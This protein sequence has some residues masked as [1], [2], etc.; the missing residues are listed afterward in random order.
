MIVEASQALPH[1]QELAS[2]AA[3][4]VS[5][6]KPLVPAVLA[7][8]EESLN[9]S[10]MTILYLALALRGDESFQENALEILAKAPA[11]N[12]YFRQ[13]GQL[14]ERLLTDPNRHDP[15]TL[16]ELVKNGVQGGDLVALTA[17]ACY[18]TG[19]DAWQTFRAESRNLL[20]KQALPGHVVRLVHYLPENRLPLARRVN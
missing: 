2:L 11:N 1:S 13:A 9:E 8:A 15:S 18:R 10:F 12:P 17:M 6:S 19:G 5:Q 3:L 4:A 14:A 7:E 20:G 16:A